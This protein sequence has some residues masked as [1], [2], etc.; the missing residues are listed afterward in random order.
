M[1]RNI[2]VS[3]AYMRLLVVEGH[4]HMEKYVCM[5]ITSVYA[6]VLHASAVHWFYSSCMC[7]CLAT[8]LCTHKIS[9]NTVILLS[10]MDDDINY[11]ATLFIRE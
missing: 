9:L 8:I 7:A 3:A 6:C 4:L 5:L 2:N 1:L 11:F 10:V